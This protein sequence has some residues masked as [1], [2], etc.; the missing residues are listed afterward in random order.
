VFRD[1]RG[2]KLRSDRYAAAVDHHHALRTLPTTCLA[3]REAPFFAGTKVASRNA[4][5]QSNSPR[6][7]IRASSF[8]QARNQTPCS[9][10]K[11][12]RRQQV[13]PSGYSSGRSRHRAPVR[14]THKIPCKQARL[15]A[16]SRPRPSL[17]RFG[18]GNNGSSTAHCSSLNKAGRFF[19]EE[20]HHPAR[21]IQ[22]SLS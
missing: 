20:A 5:C 10:H 11:R 1:L 2:R 8:C 22:K 9:S 17:R 12:N 3:D 4:S 6:S 15:D 21:I 19:I 18:S 13:E 7:S 14:R 16:H